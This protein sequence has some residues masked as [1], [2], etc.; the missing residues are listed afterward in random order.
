[1][2]VSICMV[3]VLIV[4][5]NPVIHLPLRKGVSNAIESAVCPDNGIHR[6]TKIKLMQMDLALPILLRGYELAVYIL[7]IPNEG[8]YPYQIGIIV[9]IDEFFF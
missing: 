8:L 4:P 1:M 7:C 6:Q 5:L 9:L 3:E 2:V